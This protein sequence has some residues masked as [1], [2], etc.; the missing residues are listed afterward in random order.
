MFAFWVMT[1]MTTRTVFTT[2]KV[3]VCKTPQS[4]GHSF[5]IQQLII[6]GNNNG[7]CLLDCSDLV[8]LLILNSHSNA[9]LRALCGWCRGGV[10]RNSRAHDQ[11]DSVETVQR[12]CHLCSS[13][14]PI[15]SSL[16]KS[17]HGR[18]HGPSHKLWLQSGGT[19]P[20][21]PVRVSGL[22]WECRPPP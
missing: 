15:N 18:F 17:Y 19:I 13:V 12:A 21:P 14:T 7:S 2:V 11:Y 9:P 6:I 3:E 4:F 8:D 5:T 22:P 10:A 1:C 16:A 20:Q